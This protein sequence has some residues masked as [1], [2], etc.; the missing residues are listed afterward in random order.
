M[1]IC[2]ISMKINIQ[3]KVDVL[4]AQN[5]LRRLRLQMGLKGSSEKIVEMWLIFFFFFYVFL[6]LTVR[7][8]LNHPGESIHWK[9]GVRSLQALSCRKS[10]QK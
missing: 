7:P 3:H 4:R 8:G 10:K 1:N 2:Q 9:R 6:L 5:I